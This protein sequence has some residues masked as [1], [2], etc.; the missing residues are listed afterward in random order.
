MCVCVGGGQER[1]AV[2]AQVME[3][4]RAAPRFQLHPATPCL[5]W[6]AGFGVRALHGSMTALALLPSRPSH[7][8]PTWQEGE[9]RSAD[10]VIGRHR[11]RQ[12]ERVHSQVRP[13]A[14]FHAKAEHVHLGE[15]GRLQQG[16]CSGGWG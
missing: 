9:A 11:G 15:R 10:L 6:M 16:H 2:N 4:K 5:P 12:V 7:A 3:P 1:R 8:A 13:K 14:Q